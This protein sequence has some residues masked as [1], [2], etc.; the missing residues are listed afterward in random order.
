MGLLYSTTT[1]INTPDSFEAVPA[2]PAATK[3]YLSLVRCN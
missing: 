2:P 1:P 3:G